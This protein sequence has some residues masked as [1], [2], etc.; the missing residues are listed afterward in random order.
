[1]GDLLGIWGGEAISDLFLEDKSL[2]EKLQSIGVP[3]LIH[4]SIPR[5]E[6]E[7]TGFLEKTLVKVFLEYKKGI[8]SDTGID[9]HAVKKIESAQIREIFLK[10]DAEFELLTQ[11]QKWD[12]P[13]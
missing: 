5:G 2:I 4:A 3:C 6:L 10:G 1:M 11:N 12:S 13:L 7:L 8:K 9:V